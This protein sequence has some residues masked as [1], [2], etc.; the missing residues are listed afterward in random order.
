[1]T[2]STNEN[3]EI[4]PLSAIWC[5]TQGVV[6]HPRSENVTLFDIV[7][8][9][10]GSFKWMTHARVAVVSESE[11]SDRV[12]MGVVL[13]QGIKTMGLYL[14]FEESGRM[15]WILSDYQTGERLADGE[16]AWR[17]IK[18]EVMPAGKSVRSIN[19]A[20]MMANP[21]KLRGGMEL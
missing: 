4:K 14:V 3:G 15:G 16:K 11:N 10:T 9:A 20:M 2:T 6:P 17:H 7:T 21:L 5:L 18:M 8:L 13:L 1:M 19:T 12:E